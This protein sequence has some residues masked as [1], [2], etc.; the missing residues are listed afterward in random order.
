MRNRGWE[1][2]REYLKGDRPV[3]EDVCA[4]CTYYIQG[5]CWLQVTGLFSITHLNAASHS[6]LPLSVC[7][8][9]WEWQPEVK[10]GVA[11]RAWQKAFYTW[12]INCGL[13]SET[14]LYIMRD[15]KQME[16]M[17]WWFAKFWMQKGILWAVWNGQPWRID[18]SRC[19]WQSYLK[20][21]AN[22]W[23]SQGQYETMVVQVRVG[24][25]LSLQELGCSSCCKH[26]WYIPPQNP[27]YPCPCWATK[28]IIFMKSSMCLMFGWQENRVE[29]IQL[30]TLL[31]TAARVNNLPGG[32]VPGLGSLFWSSKTSFFTVQAIIPTVHDEGFFQG[33][34][35]SQ[36][37]IIDEK[38][39]QV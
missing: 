23:W 1:Y 37:M 29:W 20:M 10:L 21:W 9:D 33:Y 4:L 16:N 11:P 12:D 30:R 39:H 24:K 17:S 32:L 5:R 34:Q 35:I 19:R 22:Q 27:W 13:L 26:M 25:V 14:T 15:T 28:K 36:T 31:V 7:L 3:A 6:W 2:P 18:Q 8:L 38:E